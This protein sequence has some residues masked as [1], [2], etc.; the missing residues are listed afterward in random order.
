MC[1]SS[2]IVQL[3]KTSERERLSLAETQSIRRGDLARAEP[4]HQA[5]SPT[6][7]ESSKLLLDL[8]RTS[9]NENL[10]EALTIDQ[11]LNL[12]SPQFLQMHL[13]LVPTST[14][15]SRPAT[16][17]GTTDNMARPIFSPWNSALD[18]RCQ[19]LE[20]STLSSHSTNRRPETSVQGPIS[21]PRSGSHSRQQSINNISTYSPPSGRSGE[22]V[23]LSQVCHDTDDEG[24]TALHICA[25]RGNF[26]MVQLLLSHDIDVESI[27]NQERTAL[28]L[29]ASRGHVLVMET[30]LKAGADPDAIDC[31]G[32]SP[33][34]AAVDSECEGAIRLLVREGAD[35]N[36]PIKVDSR[37]ANEVGIRGNR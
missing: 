32:M 34:H 36:A 22:K 14:E 10:E 25:A 27:D 9:T 1:S 37:R 18:N 28:H 26:S 17:S 11:Y 12:G 7:V 23:V 21:P 33:I 24:K 13:D 6:T 2:N 19:S 4:E 15:T 29:A 5:H 8:K 20:L 3:E 30:L 16:S 31:H 35:L